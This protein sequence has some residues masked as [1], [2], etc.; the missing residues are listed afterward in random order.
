MQLKATLTL[1]WL[2]QPNAVGVGV[3]VCVTDGAARSSFATT[4]PPPVLPTR[5]VAE[6]VNVWPPVSTVWLA[7]AGVGPLATPEPVSVADQLT[8]TGEVLF[9]PAA[10]GAGET[11][12]VTVGAVL[13]S[14]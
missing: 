6:D 7:L 1:A 11:A 2:F 9:Q 14:V 5:S 3:T 10:F 4:E 12:P 13:S 8:E